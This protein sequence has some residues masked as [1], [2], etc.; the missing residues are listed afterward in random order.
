MR[1]GELEQRQNSKE[2]GAKEHMREREF[3]LRY[4]KKMSFSLS[5][6]SDVNTEESLGVNPRGSRY[7][8]LVCLPTEQWKSLRGTCLT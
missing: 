6:T 3:V 1:A 8:A 5:V 7:S 4:P 2:T